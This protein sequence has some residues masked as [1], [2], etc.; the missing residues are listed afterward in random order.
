MYCVARVPHMSLG[1]MRCPMVP[2]CRGMARQLHNYIVGALIAGLLAD[3]FGLTWAITVVGT[4]TPL[5]GALMAVVMPETLNTERGS[6]SS[7]HTANIKITTLTLLTNGLA[8]SRI[9]RYKEVAY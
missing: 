8:A 6:A 3:R 4:L 2:H 5:S 1:R 7:K 9:P